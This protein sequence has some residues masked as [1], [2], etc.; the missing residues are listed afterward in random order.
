MS[1][2]PNDLKYSDSHEWVR[3]DGDNTVTVG[4]T[5]HAQGLLGDLVYVELPECDATLQAG[6]EAGVVESVKAASDVYCPVNGEVIEVNDKLENA[7][8]LVNTDPYGNGWLYRVQLSDTAELDSL[9]TAEN[10]QGC[11]E[12]DEE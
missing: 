8:E 3:L 10:Y 9:M 6:E 4:I 5:D 7:P 12:A 2:I 11:I 1:D